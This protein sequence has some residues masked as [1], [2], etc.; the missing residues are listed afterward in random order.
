MAPDPTNTLI[1]GDEFDERLRDALMDVLAEMG[2]NITDK[3]FGV[4]GSQELESLVVDVV[5]KSVIVEAETY[6]GISITGESTLVDQIA[7]M[8]KRRLDAGA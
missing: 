8:V 2:A 3:S 4:G 5:G 6:V 1:L 7:E